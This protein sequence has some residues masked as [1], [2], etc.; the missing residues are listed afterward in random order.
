ME[1]IFSSPLLG[2]TDRLTATRSTRTPL[3]C[4]ERRAERN[5]SSPLL[6]ATDRLLTATRSTRTPLPCGERRVERKFSSPQL[7]P[8]HKNNVFE[9]APARTLRLREDPTRCHRSAEQ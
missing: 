7:G 1:R 5:F 3:P 2:A 8:T 4:G 6:G 9:L